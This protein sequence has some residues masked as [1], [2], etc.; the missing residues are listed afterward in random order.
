MKRGNIIEKDIK[1][2]EKEF[3]L[4]EKKMWRL[5]FHFHYR[6]ILLLI[7]LAILS[8]I[9][10]RNPD[11]QSFVSSLGKL[12][13]LGVFIAGMLFTFGFT[14]L[15]AVGFFI[16]LNPVNPILVAIVGGIGALL[17]DLLIFSLIRFSFIDEFE[18]LEKTKVIKAIR[19]EINLHLSHKAKLYFLYTLAGLIIASPL[20]DEVGVTM[21]AGLTHIKLRVIAIISFIF[22][23]LGILIMTLI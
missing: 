15:F 21:L 18:R 2:I 8:Y 19:K 23:S 22:N 11:V 4:I 7:I 5:V 16:V 6:K 13:Y 3:G 9:I 20:P 17:G 1:L 14:T 10:F 12:E